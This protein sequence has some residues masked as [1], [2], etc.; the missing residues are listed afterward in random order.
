MQ[1]VVIVLSVCSVVAGCGWLVLVGAHGG[2]LGSLTGLALACG[3][4]FFF[5]VAVTGGLDS[6]F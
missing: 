4:W 3:G 6:V 2:F 1:T 5:L